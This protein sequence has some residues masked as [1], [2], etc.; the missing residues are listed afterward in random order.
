MP[1]AGRE[2]NAAAHVAKAFHRQPVGVADR[3]VRAGKGVIN[4]NSSKSI[5]ESV[6]HLAT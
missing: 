6:R 1:S 3:F 4:I 5:R 2:H